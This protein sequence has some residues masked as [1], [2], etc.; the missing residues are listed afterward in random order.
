MVA[1]R[2]GLFNVQEMFLLHIWKSLQSV[3]KE[4]LMEGVYMEIP[5]K[6]SSKGYLY[7]KK[8]SISQ[9]GGGNEIRKLGAAEEPGD[10]KFLRPRHSNKSML[11]TEGKKGQGRESKWDNSKGPCTSIFP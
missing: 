10:A 8:K 4:I 1:E 9:E 7:R 2:P 6:H 5:G 3:E 11:V